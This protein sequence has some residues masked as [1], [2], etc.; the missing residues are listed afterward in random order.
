MCLCVPKSVVMTM[1]NASRWLDDTLQSILA[2]TFAGTLELSI[3]NDGST[4]SRVQASPYDLI[5]T[6]IGYFNG[7]HHGIYSKVGGTRYPR[8]LQWT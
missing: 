5:W 6:I 8:N 7:A 4:V 1:Y 2:Q 3:Y